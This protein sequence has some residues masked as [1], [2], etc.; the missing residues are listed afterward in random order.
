MNG[1]VG[2]NVRAGARALRGLA[3]AILSVVVAAAAAAPVTLPEVRQALSTVRASEGSAV[4][5]VQVV[6]AYLDENRDSPLAMAYLGSVRTMQAAKTRAP[7]KR[8]ASMSRGFDLLDD[9]VDM[10]NR[11][12]APDAVAAEVLLVCGITNASVPT[13][14]RRGSAARANFEALLARAGFTQL[15]RANQARVHAW[16]AV[17]MLDAQPALAAAHL[18]QAR[19]LDAAAADAVWNRRPA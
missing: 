19:R 10:L 18:A 17:L 13:V 3:V 4:P 8:L 9:A 16:L 5:A 2:A 11:A 14:F 15:D 7:W 6:E 1:R 12:R